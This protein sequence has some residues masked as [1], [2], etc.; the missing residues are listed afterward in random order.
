MSFWATHPHAG[1]GMLKGWGER[2]LHGYGVFTSN[3]DGQFR[4]AGFDPKTIAECHGSIHHLQCRL[5]QELRRATKDQARQ[6]SKD[7]CTAD[8]SLPL[9]P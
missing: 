2:M 3:V 6:A 5:T 9:V 8:L 7:S 4:R 1:F